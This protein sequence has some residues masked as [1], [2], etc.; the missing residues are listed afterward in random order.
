MPRYGVMVTKQM[1]GKGQLTETGRDALLEQVKNVYEQRK[2]AYQNSV[3]FADR[4]AKKEGGT[5]DDVM[6][7]YIAPEDTV[8]QSKVD[9]IFE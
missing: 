7:V 4:A 6:P 3:D 9:S 8:P 1:V 2:A 5:I